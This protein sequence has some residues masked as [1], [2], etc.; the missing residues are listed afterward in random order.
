MC[1]AAGPGVPGLDGLGQVGQHG[2]RISR[3]GAASLLR[4][5]YIG[6][7]AVRVGVPRE[8][9]AGERR[10]A[11]VPDSVGRLAQ[12]GISVIVEPGA[13]EPASYLDEAY[14]RRVLR[15]GRRGTRR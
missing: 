2:A 5:T 8:T 15:S 3:S 9:A 1:V 6:S 11:L 14:A 13:G 10:V 7:P 4:R 12:S